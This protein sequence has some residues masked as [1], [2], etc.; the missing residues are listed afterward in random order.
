M[1]ISIMVRSCLTFDFGGLGHRQKKSTKDR[2][3]PPP[4]FER[5]GIKMVNARVRNAK[6][7]IIERRF[8]ISKTVYQDCLVHTQAVTL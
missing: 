3:S 4:I 2:F 7:K 8:W 5:L 1:C 6:A